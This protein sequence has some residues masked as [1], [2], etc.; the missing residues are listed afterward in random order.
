MLEVPVFLSVI[1]FSKEC[2]F[3]LSMPVFDEVVN[4]LGKAMHFLKNKT[5][6][7]KTVFY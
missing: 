6:Q 4:T 5:K 3:H 7:N 2:H 1:S